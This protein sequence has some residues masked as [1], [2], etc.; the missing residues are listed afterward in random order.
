MAVSTGVIESGKV[1]GL[2][3]QSLLM[4]FSVIACRD[5]LFDRAHCWCSLVLLAVPSPQEFQISGC[6]FI[7][8]VVIDTAVRPG[9]ALF[10]C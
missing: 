7:L 5:P 2:S 9:R 10:F 6:W 3:G 8:Q 4:F 1:L